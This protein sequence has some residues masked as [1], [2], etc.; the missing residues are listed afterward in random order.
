M[1]LLR[2]VTNGFLPSWRHTFAIWAANF[3]PIHKLKEMRFTAKPI[4]RRV[5][6]RFETDALPEPQPSFQSAPFSEVVG[7]TESHKS[8]QANEL[9]PGVEPGTSSLRMVTGGFP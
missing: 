8:R 4:S 6:T 2:T 9:V 7:K 3:I 5:L 1:H